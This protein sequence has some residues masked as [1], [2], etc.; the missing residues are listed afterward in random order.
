M[1]KIRR[2]PVIGEMSGKVGQVVV[3]RYRDKYVI[4]SIPVASAHRSP[5]QKAHTQRFRDAMEY[6]KLKTRESPTDEL[7]GRP[8]HEQGKAANTLAVSDF[9]RPPVIRK[10]D[11]TDY[12]GKAGA[13]LTVMVDNIIQ[14]R[15]VRVTIVDSED[16]PVEAGMGKMVKNNIWSYTTTRDVESTGQA[17]GATVVIVAT[18]HPGNIVEQ[19]VEQSFPN[20]G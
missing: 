6:A 18:D 2:I 1:A 3:K 14:V 5:K 11:L 13:R 9:F 15:E 20:D 19:R 12:Q 10:V 8:A 4:T 17:N 16:K 7:Y